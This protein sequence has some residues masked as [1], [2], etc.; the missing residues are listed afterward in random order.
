MPNRKRARIA[1]GSMTPSTRAVFSEV[2]LR[3]PLAR[4]ELARRLGLSPASLTKLTRP[5]IDQGLLREDGARPLAETGRPALPLEVVPGRTHV[6]GVKLNPDDLFAVRTD[7]RARVLEEYECKL[8][9]HDPGSVEEAIAMAVESLDPSRLAERVGVSLAG[10]IRPGDQMVREAPYM[11]WSGVPLATAVALRV[12]RPVVLTNDV[13]ALTVAEHWFGAGKQSRCFAVL[14]VGKGVGCGLVVNN[15][16]VTG[17]DGHAG[18][19]SHVPVVPSGPLCRQ[20]HRGCASAYLTSGSIVR[21]L[22]ATDGF[23]GATFEEALEAARAG[24]P[25]AVRVF[26]DACFALGTLAAYIANMI[27]PDRIVLSGEGIGMYEIAPELVRAGISH[28][29]HWNASPFNLDVEP[30]AFSEWARGAA[31][32]AVQSLIFRGGPAGGP[33]GPGSRAW[34]TNGTSS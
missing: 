34:G 16:V 1:W 4:A 10:N 28:V 9:R 8:E 13:R 33:G 27:G 14:T 19:V 5:L 15:A 24:N 23:H 29:I 25:P 11:G 18:L 7:L 3:G 22:A 30:F 17:Y 2:L 32:V 6:I 31:A 21:T 20:G 12:R 26:Q